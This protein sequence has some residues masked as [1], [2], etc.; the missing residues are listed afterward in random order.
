[1]GLW[2]ARVI[3]VIKT[4]KKNKTKKNIKKLPSYRNLSINS[5]WKLI[6]WFLYDSNFGLYWVNRK[7]SIFIYGHY[8]TSL[9]FASFILFHKYGQFTK[10]SF[11][12]Q[13]TLLFPSRFLCNIKEKTNKLASARI[14]QKHFM[15]TSYQSKHSFSLK[16]L[17]YFTS[18]EFLRPRSP[19]R[20]K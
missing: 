14:W 17:P 11:S 16:K 9:F 2:P 1:M 12:T 19:Q 10:L 15:Y 18:K 8:K 7:N 6:D 13:S 20:N 3:S 5:L 4:I